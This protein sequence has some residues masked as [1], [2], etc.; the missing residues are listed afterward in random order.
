MVRRGIKQT[1]S[2]TND[3]KIAGE[4]GNGPE[5]LALLRKQKADLLLLDISMP[6]HNGLDVLKQIKVE[7]PALKVLM[8]SIY[9]EEQ[10]AVRALKSGAAGYLTKASA[11]NELIIAI[12]RVARGGK[13]ITASLAE[14]LADDLLQPESELPHETLSDREY[15]VFLLLAAGITVSKIAGELCLSAKTISTHRTR[16]LEKMNMKSNADLA[17]Y[18]VSKKLVDY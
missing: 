13:Y 9:S 12:R 4:A 16:L 5:L 11:A 18:A 2:E 7:F 8:L 6:G 10:Y 3:I 1:I 17:R 14:K 15:Q